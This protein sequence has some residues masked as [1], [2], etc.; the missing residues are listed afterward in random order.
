MQC[1]HAGYLH[2][3]HSHRGAYSS[4]QIEV[5]SVKVALKTSRRIGLKGSGLTID[6]VITYHM[7][8]IKNVVIKVFK[9]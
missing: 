9:L 4:D 5:S 2:H 6:V 8:G 3:A 1:K 7:N